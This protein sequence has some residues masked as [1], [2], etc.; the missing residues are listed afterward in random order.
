M[1]GPAKKPAESKLRRG[2][3]GKV[4]KR[5]LEAAV[6]AGSVGSGA[7]ADAPLVIDPPPHLD[8]EIVEIWKWYT[9][10]V[11]GQTVV[12]SGDV[13]ALERLCTYYYQW[14]QCTQALRERRSKTGLRLTTT[15]K[16][17]G[18]GDVTKVRPEAHHRATLESH[19][20]ALEAQFGA[21]P[22]GR[23][24]VMEKLAGVR[25]GGAK[26]PLS[27]P[28]GSRPAK[29]LGEADGVPPPP[30]SPIGVLGGKRLN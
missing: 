8:P 26:P 7:A 6:A 17:K 30:S 18:Y 28:P 10:T 13:L 16:R 25:D 15:E 24:A 5:G 4:N 2:N 29:V 23:A 9:G 12:R 3:P 14:R 22:S 21:T 19:I 1:P 27:D 20:R 11:V